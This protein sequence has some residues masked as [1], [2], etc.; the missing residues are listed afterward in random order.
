MVLS[1]AGAVG[2]P[3]VSTD[4]GAIGE[5]VR[6]ERDR[7]ARTRRRRRALGRRAAPAGRR[8]RRC[9]GASAMQARRVVHADFDAA[10]NARRLVELLLAVASGDAP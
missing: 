7:A 10:A 9:A 5:I 3:L 8:R 2:L 4:V 6:D 1:E